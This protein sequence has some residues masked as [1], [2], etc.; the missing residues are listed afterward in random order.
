MAPTIQVLASHL[1]TLS[2]IVIDKRFILKCLTSDVTMHIVKGISKH[3]IYSYFHVTAA[4]L[5][6]TQQSQKPSTEKWGNTFAKH[7][8]LI[9]VTLVAGF[10]AVTKG[11][12]KH[13]IFGHR[14]SRQNASAYI[15]MLKMAFCYYSLDRLK[16][17]P[18]DLRWSQ[19]WMDRASSA[20]CST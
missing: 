3:K 16:S 20:L 11:P 15:P 19:L 12:W 18:F 2:N 6:V 14:R 9:R 10:C 7:S 5:E 17:D 4:L 8:W 13:F 1:Q